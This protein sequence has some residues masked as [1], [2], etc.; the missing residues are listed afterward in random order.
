MAI[1]NEDKNQWKP[2]VSGNIHGRPKGAKNRATILKKWL[3]L[4][5]EVDDPLTGQ[6]TTGTIE[7]RIALALITKGLKE[8]VAA[9]KEILDSVYGKPKQE[10]MPVELNR[11]IRPLPP[12]EDEE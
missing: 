8:D 5:C 3:D 12:G 1:P 7:D 10:E 11:V 9:I 6:P 4:P 2:G